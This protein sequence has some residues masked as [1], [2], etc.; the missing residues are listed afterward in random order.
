MENSCF[1][2]VSLWKREKGRMFSWYNAKEYRNLLVLIGITLFATMLSGCGSASVEA[3]SPIVRI[4]AGEIAGSGVIYEKKEDYLV[5]VTAGHVLQSATDSVEV[6]FE[7]GSVT[8]SSFYVISNSSDV[9]FIRVETDKQYSAVSID[10][11]AF[12]SLSAGEKLIMQGSNSDGEM[13]EISGTLI[14]PWIFAEDFNQYMMLIRG[15]ILPGMSGGAVF[16]EAGCFV[17]ILCGTNEELREVAAVPLSIIMAE[18]E[19]IGE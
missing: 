2:V 15:E 4:S 18:Y 16:D 14:Y 12:D 10:K 3:L 5:I 8:E 7:D 6:I 17:G 1:I 9:A 13:E 11:E 19:L